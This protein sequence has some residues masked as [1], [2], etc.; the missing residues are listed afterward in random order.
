[1]LSFV[2]FFV[3]RLSVPLH[4]PPPPHDPL[5]MSLQIEKKQKKRRLANLLLLWDQS[6][7]LC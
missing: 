5:A 3:G 4:P 7:R 2:L 1:M 6:R